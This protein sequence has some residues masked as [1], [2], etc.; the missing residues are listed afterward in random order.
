V[1]N[2]PNGADLLAR[3]LSRSGGREDR[4]RG[5]LLLLF[6]VIVETLLDS[7]P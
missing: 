7:S 2:D 5:N 1:D 6:I 3:T 4:V